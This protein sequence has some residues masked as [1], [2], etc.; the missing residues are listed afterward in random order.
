M[1]PSTTPNNTNFDAQN[2]AIPLL[3]IFR[4]Q[5]S[6]LMVRC[7][8]KMKICPCLRAN[9]EPPKDALASVSLTTEFAPGAGFIRL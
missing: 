6:T 9:V 7:G 3:L 8:S 5:E 2:P 1:L 4:K